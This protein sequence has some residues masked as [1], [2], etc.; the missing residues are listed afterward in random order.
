MLPRAFDITIS[1]W[2]AILCVL[3]FVELFPENIT[4]PNYRGICISSCL[5]KLFCSILNN[6][7]LNFSQKH[8]IIHHSQI[9]FL[10]GH[11]TSNHIFPLKTLI[12]KHVTRAPKGKLYT[13]FVDLK[14]AF[15]SIWHQGLL[16]KLLKHN[17]GGTFYEIISNMYLQSKC[18]VKNGYNQSEFF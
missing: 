5:E 13:C 16:Y 14:K 12:E 7:L 8:K 11:C 17:I 1:C 4:P 10:P 6:R 15:E 18:C 2:S 3:L 9:G